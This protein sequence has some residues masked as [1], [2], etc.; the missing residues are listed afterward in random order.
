[1][2]YI[3]ALGICVAIVGCGG[4]S[5]G[6]KELT[7]LRTAPRNPNAR[8]DAEAAMAPQGKE[9]P[10]MAKKRVLMHRPGLR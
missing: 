2:K 5:E 6:Q 8:K 10:M 1:M 7:D 4:P 9:T 3:L